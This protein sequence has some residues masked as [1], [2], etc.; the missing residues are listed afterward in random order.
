MLIKMFFFFVVLKM[1]KNSDHPADIYPNLLKSPP[2]FFPKSVDLFENTKELFVQCDVTKIFNHFK[3]SSLHVSTQAHLEFIL[4]MFPNPG[5]TDPLFKYPCLTDHSIYHT[6]TAE[7]VSF[8]AHG[9]PLPSNFLEKSS[10]ESER[11]FIRMLNHDRGGND[12]SETMDSLCGKSSKPLQSLSSSELRKIYSQWEFENPFRSLFCRTES[13]FTS[14][15]LCKDEALMAAVAGWYYFTLGIKA[16]LGTKENRNLRPHMPFFNF[17]EENLMRRTMCVNDMSQTTIQALALLACFR[18]VDSQPRCGWALLS[19]AHELAKEYLIASSLKE[20]NGLKHGLD[21]ELDPCNH[22][23]YSLY[24]LLSLFRAWTQV[25]M[26]F[27]YSSIKNIL[28]DLPSMLKKINPDSNMIAKDCH[29]GLKDK[30]T[31]SLLSNTSR[32]VEVICTLL[33]DDPAFFQ[34]PENDKITPNNEKSGIKSHLT[35]WLVDAALKSK[36]PEHEINHNMLDESGNSLVGSTKTSCPTGALRVVFSIFALSRMALLD[37]SSNLSTRISFKSSLKD[38]VR[39]LKVINSEGSTN[40]LRRPSEPF[41][42]LVLKLLKSFLPSLTSLLENLLEFF[43]TMVKPLT[44]DHSH[45]WRALTVEIDALMSYTFLSSDFSSKEEL[46]NLERLKTKIVTSNVIDQYECRKII[47][48]RQDTLDIEARG[49]EDLQLKTSRHHNENYSSILENKSD[50]FGIPPVPNQF[51]AIGFCAAYSDPATASSTDSTPT[52]NSAGYS[53]YPQP[54]LLISSSSSPPNSSEPAPV[55][56]NYYQINYLAN[57]KVDCDKQLRCADFPALV[58]GV[59]EAKDPIQKNISL[60]DTD[61]IS[62]YSKSRVLGS[63]EPQ[64]IGNSW[65]AAENT[66]SDGFSGNYD[67]NFYTH[68]PITSK[69]AVNEEMVFQSLPDY[70]QSSSNFSALQGIGINLEGNSMKSTSVAPKS[71]QISTHPSYLN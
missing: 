23:I 9:K 35:R 69:G 48:T 21:R 32:I 56:E 31:I 17:A 71:S 34:I 39:L 51:S 70:Q 41:Q 2:V 66:M 16:R 15:I 14:E 64:N 58:M 67:E 3:G 37:H 47:E 28:E 25:S 29:E 61:K 68:P 40:E 57:S 33:R 30:W 50:H 63:H 46:E 44:T 11:V 45:I 36:A 62:A 53:A 5:I 24:L 12:W 60:S 52:F 4:T 1:H 43:L 65:G 54:P 19:V 55:G 59:P 6:I 22:G 20:R 42:D 18:I 38:V 13:F 27:P 49:N 26:S 7:L 8:H 10:R